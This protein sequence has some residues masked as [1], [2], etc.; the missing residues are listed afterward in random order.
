MAPLYLTDGQVGSFYNL[1]NLELHRRQYRC[2]R[3]QVK[4]LYQ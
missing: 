4:K 3:S 2:Q 1:Y